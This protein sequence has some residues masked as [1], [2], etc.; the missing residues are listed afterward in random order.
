MSITT[1]T[2]ASFTI[3]AEIYTPLNHPRQTEIIHGFTSHL[4]WFII[5]TTKWLVPPLALAGFPISLMVGIL[6]LHI[7]GVL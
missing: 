5:D 4:E 7:W 6:A 2:V 1:K 3:P